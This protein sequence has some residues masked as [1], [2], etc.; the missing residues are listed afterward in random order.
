MRNAKDTLEKDAVG[1]L[2]A[3]KSN[4]KCLYATVFAKENG[5]DVMGQLDKLFGAE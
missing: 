4:G 2:W 1:R 5:L 3:G